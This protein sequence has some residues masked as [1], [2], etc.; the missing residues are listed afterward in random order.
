MRLFSL[1]KTTISKNLNQLI[2]ERFLIIIMKMKHVSW[3]HSVSASSFLFFL[4]SPFFA[5]SRVLAS[6][7]TF[8]LIL[9]YVLIFCSFFFPTYFVVALVCRCLQWVSGLQV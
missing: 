1:L 9:F 6:N 4:W 8:Y 7:F 2:N 5:Q 3:Q